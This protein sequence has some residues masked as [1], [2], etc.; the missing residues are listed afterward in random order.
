MEA[1]RYR[2]GEAIRWLSA[3][4]DAQRR[5]AKEKGKQLRVDPAEVTFK[6]LRETFSAIAGALLDYGKGAYT[7]IM[8]RQAEAHEY[9]LSD[10]DFS[11]SRTSGPRIYKYSDVTA[12]EWDRDRAN[13]I[14]GQTT[15]TIKPY[16]YIS[17]GRIKVPIGWDRNG[18]EVPFELLVEEL[19]ARCRVEVATK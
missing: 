16:A 3:G 10:N 6:T 8:H 18:M 15:V 13:L 11:V 5:S 14:I 19:A 2:P 4:A 7:E 17:A 1:V 9:I 12:I